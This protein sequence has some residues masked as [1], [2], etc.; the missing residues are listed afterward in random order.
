MQPL[1][2][3]LDCR[4]RNKLIAGTPQRQEGPCLPLPQQLARMTPQRPR[5]NEP[6]SRNMREA[7][8]KRRTREEGDN[9]DRWQHEDD[10]GSSNFSTA[11]V[12]GGL[13][14]VGSSERTQV[15]RRRRP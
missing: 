12:P 2:A 10:L 11:P 7:A 1:A 3:E 14:A 8:R 15:R 13:P 5:N 9:I 6:K 4:C